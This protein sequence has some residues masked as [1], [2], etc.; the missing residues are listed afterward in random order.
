MGETDV[1]QWEIELK[2]NVAQAL[3]FEAA[4]AYVAANYESLKVIQL[5]AEREGRFGRFLKD[6]A[7]LFV[8]SAPDMDAETIAFEVNRL[9]VAE[10]GRPTGIIFNGVQL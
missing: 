6:R 7:P 5:T 2:A 4:V 9:I 1:E 10:F 3:Q 8:D